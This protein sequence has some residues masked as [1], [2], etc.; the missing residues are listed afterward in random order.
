[1]DM[2]KLTSM[3]GVEIGMFDLIPILHSF[4][5]RGYA[6]GEYSQCQRRKMKFHVHIHSFIHPSFACYTVLVF[7]VDS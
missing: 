3:V 1:M 5:Y 7:S 4:M 6:K 2:E